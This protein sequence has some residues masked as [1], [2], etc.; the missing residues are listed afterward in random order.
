M[1]I[2]VNG[3]QRKYDGDPDRPLLWVLRE[4]LGLTGTKYGCGVAA[5]GACTVM[6]EGQPQRACAVPMSAV[7][8]QKIT[9]IEAL[10]TKAAKAVQQ[11]WTEL[12]VVQCGWC[13]S[14]QIMT[15]AALLS[16]SP[17]PTEEQIKTGMDNNLCRCVTYQRIVAGVSRAAGILAKG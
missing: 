8:G 1:D 15:A 17:A 3:Q 2:T 7:A 6:I 12:D 16:E 4:D 14:G 5:C 11:A 13:Q 9:T 10:D